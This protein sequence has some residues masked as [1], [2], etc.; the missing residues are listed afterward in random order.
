[1]KN[2]FPNCIN[3]EH[4]QHFWKR[5]R[6]CAQRMVKSIGCMGAT[7]SSS[8]S[9]IKLVKITRRMKSGLKIRNRRFCASV[10]VTTHYSLPDGLRRQTIVRLLHECLPD[11][12]ADATQKRCKLCSIR[13]AIKVKTALLSWSFFSTVCMSTLAF[14]FRSIQVLMTNWARKVNVSILYRN[15]WLI[16]NNILHTD[17][18]SEYCSK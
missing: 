15:Y 13:K 6:A 17:Q 12:H 10:Y 1:M 2:V 9:L 7:R 8:S 14:L 18:T 5:R 11:Q 16:A 3:L 4:G